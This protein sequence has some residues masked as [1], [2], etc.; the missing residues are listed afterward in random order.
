MQR[1]PPTRRPAGSCA[2]IVEGHGLPP[3][4]GWPTSAA[5]GIKLPARAGRTSCQLRRATWRTCCAG[6]RARCR[7]STRRA[8][9]TTWSRP[10]AAA[11]SASRTRPR[12]WS[13]RCAWSCACAPS[14]S[15]WRPTSTARSRPS[16]P[17]SPARASAWSRPRRP[18]ARR[19]PSS[20]SAPSPPTARTRSRCS[21]AGCA[22]AWSRS[23]GPGSPGDARA[24]ELGLRRAA[25]RRHRAEFLGRPGALPRGQRAGL[26]DAAAL[27]RRA[28]APRPAAHVP[29]P[30]H[31]DPPRLRRLPV[32]AFASRWRP[33][34]PI[35]AD[36]HLPGDPQPGRDAA[37]RARQA[38]GLRRPVGHA[39][40]AR[41]GRGLVGLAGDGRRTC[42]AAS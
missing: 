1:V 2:Q 27:R 28:A 24:V 37:R 39:R 17:S 30:T 3:A 8:A 29:K 33:R 4:H 15:R 34:F 12:A 16:W 7:R 26:P 23:A 10:C 21:T 6:A 42:S 31:D 22:I 41:L 35:L 14:A 38:G 32:D 19:R 11:W 20:S 25:L 36:T 40:R 5:T 9:A 13:W 18:A